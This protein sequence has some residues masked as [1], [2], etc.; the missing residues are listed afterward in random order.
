MA[1]EGK[2]PEELKPGEEPG[3]KSEKVIKTEDY[4]YLQRQN[5]KIQKELEALR[6][7]E[8]DRKTAELSE[9]D[10]VKKVQVDLE[11]K[12]AGKEKEVRQK[13]LAL[14]KVSIFDEL[15]IP[16]DFLDFVTAEDEESLLTMAKK[17]KDSLQT[18][19]KLPGIEGAAPA[20]GQPA[21]PV[22]SE[23]QKEQARKFGF[24]PNIEEQ[25]KDFVN[26]V[27]PRIEKGIAL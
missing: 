16:H 25:A 23:I 12:L 4:F 24:D 26:T 6:K 8:E 11:A 1:E 21:R 22:L 2:P 18:K 14:R 20:G 13:D 3:K 19:I 17:F 7:T 27:L 10:K 15:Q 9:I 5:E